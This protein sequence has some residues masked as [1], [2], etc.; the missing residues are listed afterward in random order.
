M[1]MV[2]GGEVSVDPGTLSAELRPWRGLLVVGTAHGTL[3]LVDLALDLGGESSM[4]SSPWIN[5]VSFVKF[6]L[7]IFSLI[8]FTFFRS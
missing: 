6:Y 1:C 3:H 2:S 5:K 7:P 8:A 4:F